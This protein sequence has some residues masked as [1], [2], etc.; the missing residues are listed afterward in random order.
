MLTVGHR[1]GTST[2]EVASPTIQLESLVLSLLIDTKE[3]MDVSTADV[4]GAYLLADMKYYVLIRL[5][6]K[7]VEVQELCGVRER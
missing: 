4:V 5:T 3:D 6:D 1:E 7:T 2:D